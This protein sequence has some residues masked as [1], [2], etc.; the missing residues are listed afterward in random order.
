[1]SCISKYLQG[2]I[3]VNTSYRKLLYFINERFYENIVTIFIFPEYS[4]IKINEIHKNTS[5]II[6]LNI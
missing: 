4:T 6:S 3:T 1:M 5:L 2:L